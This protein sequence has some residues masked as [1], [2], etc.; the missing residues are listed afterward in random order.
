MIDH[1]NKSICLRECSTNLQVD[2]DSISAPGEDGDT[3]F[4]RSCHCCHHE[5]NI[6]LCSSPGD[7]HLPNLANGAL[8]NPFI[9]PSPPRVSSYTAQQIATLQSRLERQLGPEYISTRPGAGG[10]KVHYLAAEKSI[11]LAN[12][13]FGFNGWSSQIKDIQVD[14]ADESASGKISVGL[15]VIVR[16]TLKDGTF[17]EVCFGR[18][19]M[20]LVHG[21]LQW[22]DRILGM[23]RSRIAKARRWRLRRQRRRERRMR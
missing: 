3:L 20:I 23:D 18:V 6:S 1:N 4:R 17:H 9:P 12:E 10:Q 22:D 21:S 5:T 14:F 15:S 19:W 2:I 13:V 8:S 16:V 7:Q 11:G